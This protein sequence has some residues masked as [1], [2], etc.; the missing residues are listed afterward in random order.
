MVSIKVSSSKD[1]D[2]KYT[3]LSSSTYQDTIHVIV[4]PSGEV[5]VD[6][7]ILQYGNIV[8]LITTFFD[9]EKFIL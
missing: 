3:W 2:I 8:F 4:C 1:F 7:W 9:V 6:L 5:Q